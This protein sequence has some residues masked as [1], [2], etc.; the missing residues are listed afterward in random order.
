MS[1]N[2]LLAIVLADLLRLERRLARRSCEHGA[3][4]NV[5]LE[6]PCVQR[7]V[8]EMRAMKLARDERL[9]HAG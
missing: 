5:C 8:D 1:E 4:M 9:R 6:L 3:R 7:R 2:D